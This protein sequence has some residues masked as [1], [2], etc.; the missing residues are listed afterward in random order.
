MQIIKKIAVW[1]AVFNFCLVFGSAEA[2]VFDMTEFRL[3]NG[4]QVIVIPNHKAPIVRQMVWYKVGSVDEKI[5]KGGTAHLLEHLMFRGTK[6]VKDSWFNA[7]IAQN[8]GDSNAFTAQD[9]TSYYE[10]MDVGRLELAMALEADRMENLKI[11]KK[12]FKKERDVV[13]QERMQVV[14]NNPSAYFGEALRRVLW[15]QHPYSQSISG[16]PEEIMSLDKDDVEAFYESYYAPNNAILVLSGDIEPQTAKVLAE[17]YF[18]EIEPRKVGLKA[19]FPK[20]DKQFGARLE[21]KLPQIKSERMVKLYVAPSVN[22]DKE[23][24][25]P[26]MVLAAYL[27]EG[28]TSKL[29][30]KLVLEEK[31]AL[32][33]SASYDYASRSYGGLSISATPVDSVDT[34]IFEK[35]LNKALKQAV[36][37]INVD[38]VE[39]T[40]AKMLAGQ[41]YLRDNPNDAAYI[42][43]AMAAAGMS[44]EEI[45]NHA[46]NIRK[47]SA[48]DV[49]NA[50][51]RI[52][53]SAINVTGIIKPAEEA[54]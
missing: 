45:E 25:Y 21:M 29:Y 48:K 23:F 27:G 49:K 13:F 28:E 38:E 9:F 53:G 10:T 12:S 7:I 18:G 24:V 34:K 31:S 26:L 1:C 8:G 11:D 4:L 51:K 42:V 3:K 52:F 46:E 30:K 14:E 6:K 50:A 36:A 5:G 33:V 19:D 35:A 54:N 40:K 47:V 20:L 41:V 15:Q 44:V 39:K 22:V 16:T 43:G 2:K 32:S 17:K 37:E